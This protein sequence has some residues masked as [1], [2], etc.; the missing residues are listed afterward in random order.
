LSSI[1]RHNLIC[2]RTED[3]N[4]RPDERCCDV[5]QFSLYAT[6]RIEAGDR[7]RVEQLCPHGASAQPALDEQVDGCCA[8]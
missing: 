5:E 1:Q 7:E 4:F 2:G 3:N 8:G 6:V